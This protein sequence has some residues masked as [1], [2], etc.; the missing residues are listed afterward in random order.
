MKHYQYW[1]NLFFSTYFL[2]GQGQIF[3]SDQLPSSFEQFNISIENSQ[4]YFS[5]NN[6]KN[7]LSKVAVSLVTTTS[8]IFNY[9][10]SF[11]MQWCKQHLLPL[12]K[13][14]KYTIFCSGICSS[15]VGIQLFLLKA[16]CYFK[17]QS[18]WS[19]WMPVTASFDQGADS[20]E[21]LQKKLIFDI[22]RRYVNKHNPTDFIS[23]LVM[24]LKK[25]THEE[26][27]INSY[28]TTLNAVK[29]L[30]LKQLF[31]INENKIKKIK[32]RKKRLLSVKE[33]FLSWIAT[34]NIEQARRQLI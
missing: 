10:K 8:Y 7:I 18:L 27:Y 3:S 21:L 2:F 29:K 16:D 17:K 34:Y 14:N 11:D 33:L 31:L 24:F 6:T 30:H 25:I 5:N 28:L 19:H 23:P 20:N 1:I 9:I 4:F 13:K 22:Q 26:N 12:L 15:Y 32:L